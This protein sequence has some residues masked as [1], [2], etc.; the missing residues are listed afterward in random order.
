VARHHGVPFY[1]CAPWST[2]DRA[3]PDGEAI[4]IEQRDGDEVRFAGGVAVA[5]AGV[6]VRNPSFDV[7][8]H[9]LVTAVVTDK[10]VFRAPYSFT[11]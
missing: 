9:A 8:P 3:T 10:G 4:V 7:T 6:P 2:I 5:P 11:Y 1:V